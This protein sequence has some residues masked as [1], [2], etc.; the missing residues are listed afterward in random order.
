MVIKSTFKLRPIDKQAALVTQKA[1]AHSTFTIKNRDKLVDSEFWEAP[2][3]HK[4]IPKSGDFVDLTGAH[5]GR[6]TV[7]GFLGSRTW[8]CR[9][10]CG[11]YC[12]RTKKFIEQAL[13][14]RESTE[15]MCRECYGVMLLKKNEYFKAHGCY[16]S[17]KKKLEL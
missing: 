9:C 1:P 17:D 11:R 12:Q 7:T 13:N 14:G 10:I 3:K 4:A 16:P 15:S 2:K 5:F 6:L 8:Q